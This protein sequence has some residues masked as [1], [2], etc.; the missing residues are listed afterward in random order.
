[1]SKINIIPEEKIAAVKS[2][3]NGEGSQRSIA[4]PFAFLFRCKD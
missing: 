3:L 1:M 2:F 4:A